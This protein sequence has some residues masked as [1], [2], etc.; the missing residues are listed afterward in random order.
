MN[1]NSEIGRVDKCF[2]IGTI[3]TGSCMCCICTLFVFVL[4]LRQLASSTVEEGG[5]IIVSSVVNTSS[6]S[7][8]ATHQYQH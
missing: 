1:I 6:S 7:R 2:S 5:P 8:R 3:I 4:S